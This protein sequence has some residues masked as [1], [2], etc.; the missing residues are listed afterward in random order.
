M[1][2]PKGLEA[3][4]SKSGAV[5]RGATAALDKSPQARRGRRGASLRRVVHANAMKP[6]TE[7]GEGRG[8][9]RT[10]VPTQSIAQMIKLRL[11]TS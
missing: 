8:A 11:I 1:A 7:S 6:R 10:P 5:T 9:R 2:S 3:V 4:D